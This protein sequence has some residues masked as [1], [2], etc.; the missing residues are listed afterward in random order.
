MTKEDEHSDVLLKFVPAGGYG[1]LIVTLHES[2]SGRGASG[3]SIVEVRVDGDRV[4]QLTPQMSRRY[5]PLIHHLAARGL[6]TACRGDI[7]GSPVA[8]EV[9][10]DGVKANEADSAVL[11]GAAVTVPRLVAAQEDPTSYDLSAGAVGTAEATARHSYDGQDRARSAGAPV[12]PPLP[13]AAWYDDP[14]DPR[15]LRYWDGARW[16]EHIAPKV[17]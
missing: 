13:P 9:R 4:G 14:R 12:D 10:I 5:L 8:A 2:T 11:D 15:L 17:R 3:K 7:T 1:M 6:V 16:T